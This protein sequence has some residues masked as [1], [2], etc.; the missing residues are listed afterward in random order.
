MSRRIVVTA[1]QYQE[2]LARRRAAQPPVAAAASR[3]K[4]SKRPAAHPGPP[5]IPAGPEIPPL[6]S[7]LSGVGHVRTTLMPYVEEMLT[8]NQ[9]LHR[10]TEHKIK[11]Q[12]RADAAQMITLQRLPRLQRAAI[13]YV[14]HS[15]PIN[16]KR[17]PGNWASTAKAYI[18]GD[19]GLPAAFAVPI[20]PPHAG[21]RSRP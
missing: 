7:D 11:K 2:I 5:S 20:Y 3:K 19:Q 9:C 15:R 17:D 12:L 4:A 6:L 18:D 10:M 21:R 8:S 13:F 14:L 16:Q 1:L